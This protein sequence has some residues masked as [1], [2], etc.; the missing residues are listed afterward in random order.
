MDGCGHEEGLEGD[1]SVREALN[2]RGCSKTL[3]AKRFVTKDRWKQ[4]FAL[5]ILWF[6]VI[7][8]TYALAMIGKEDAAYRF[9]F[10]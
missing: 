3:Y 6:Y 9:S 4:P 7:F 2:S 5:C 10:N 1:L 8:R